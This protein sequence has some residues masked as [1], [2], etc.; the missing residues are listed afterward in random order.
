MKL[1]LY[2][3]KG[4]VYNK[5]GFPT[6]GSMIAFD[7]ILMYFLKQNKKCC[8]LIRFFYGIV[9]VLLEIKK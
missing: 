6:C 3:V 4:N 9:F 5:E 2:V 8:T 1:E 7:E